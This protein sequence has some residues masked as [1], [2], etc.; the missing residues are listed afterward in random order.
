MRRFFTRLFATI[1]FLVVLLICVSGGLWLWSMNRAPRIA[2]NTVL[3]IDLTDALPD[4]AG[5]GGLS[6]ILFPSGMSLADTLDAIERAGSDPRVKG[7]VARIGDSGMGLAQVQELRDAIAAFRA[8]GKHAIAYTDTF[9]E[10]SSGTRSYYLAAAFDE[11]WLQP[12]GTV[13]LTG[14]RAETPFFRGTLDMLGIVPDFEHREEYKDAA[15]MMTE[16]GMTGPEREELQALLQ[17]IYGQIVQ[18]IAAD[19]KIEPDAV[20]ALIDR[21]PLLVDDAMKSHLVDH[22]GDRDD[23]IASFGKDA[24]LLSLDRYFAQLGPLH[25]KGPTVALIY[26]TGLMA[27]G[28]G[29]ENPLSQDSIMSSDQVTRAF[30]AA[31]TDPSVRA[32]LFRIDSPGGSATAAE[33]IWNAVRRAHE[34]GKPVIVS[35]GDVAGS[36]GYY[37]AAPADKIVAEPATLTGSIGV[38]AGK[39]VFGDTL[40]KVGGNWDSVQIG[41]NAGLFSVM[42]GF[43]PVERERLNAVLDDIYANFKNRVA[44]GRKLSPD[45]V[46]AVAK[47][48]VWS[49]EDAKTHGLV[50][51]LGG[52]ATALDLAKQTAGI[53]AD[54]DVNLKLYPAPKS[55][56]DRLI[57]RVSGKSSGDEDS[58]LPQSTLAFLRASAKR[59]SLLMAPP[60]SLAMPP[61]EVK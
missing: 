18:G 58:L 25:Q 13:G 38:I 54:Q 9:G 10:L 20:K 34:A 33:T 48:R 27:R 16:T 2:A 23:A 12:M 32:I 44:A 40:K 30:H 57:A 52:F 15:N 55:A 59:L 56:V 47:G 37:I 51:A 22:V 43:S 39:L 29:A 60:G 1:G 3:S 49:G 28:G 53:A 35:M 42:Q 45:D 24:D 7:I 50:D 8:K 17:S 5:D 61:V 46:E 36:G 14:L 26:A 21:A 19:R 31:Q 4:T 6:Q 41:A 11:I